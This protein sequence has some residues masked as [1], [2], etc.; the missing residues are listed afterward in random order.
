MPDTEPDR[1]RLALPPDPELRPVVEVAVAVLVRRMGLPDAA[2]QAARTAAGQ[3]FE[4]VSG[5]ADGQE[6]A[7]V[8]S[9][10]PEGLEAELRSGTAELTVRTARRDGLS[11]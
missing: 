5:R 10:G 7:V 4:Q 11:P 2:I 9:L 6:V 8:L 1:V 3:A